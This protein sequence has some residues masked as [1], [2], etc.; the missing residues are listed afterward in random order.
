MLLYVNI[1]FRIRVKCDADIPYQGIYP[2][3]VIIIVA[4]KKSHLEHQFS[5]P[6][7]QATDEIVFNAHHPTSTLRNDLD[8]SAHV[9][10]PYS[11][12]LSDTDKTEMGDVEISKRE[13]KET[14]T[15]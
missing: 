10:I 4:L 2:T 6:E 8:G 11:V 7:L 5:Y 15:V 13:R 12:H 3:L 9:T 1:N 14:S